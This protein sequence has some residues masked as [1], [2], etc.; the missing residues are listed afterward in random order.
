MP[1][2]VEAYLKR[3]GPS[4]STEV[5]AHLV[6]TLKVSAEAARQRV[7]RSTAAH[8]LS[9]LTF[10]RRARFLYLQPQFGSPLYW[11]AL[12]TALITTNSA[13]GFAIAALRQ[14]GGVVTMAR[15]P[16][17]CG[18]PVRQSK[19]LAPETILAR[20]EGAGLVKRQTLNGLGECVTLVQAEGYYD[21]VGPRLQADAVAESILLL[22]VRDWLRK[23][24]LASYNVIALRG[25]TPPP[26]VGTFLWDLSGPSYIY[27]LTRR[28]GVGRRNGFV[29]CDVHLGSPMTPSGVEPFVRKCATLRSLTKVGGCLQILVAEQ[30]DQRAFQRL[31]SV[32]VIAATPTSL[33]GQEVAD[34][35]RELASVLENAA[36]TAI[37]P[38]RFEQLF[39]VLSKIDGAANQLRGTLFEYMA[40]ELA[41]QTLGPDVRMNRMFKVPGRG[42]AE[43]DVVAVRLNHGITV[44]ECK[45]YSPRATIPDDKF[46]RWLQHSV[47]LCHAAIQTHP[48]WR[49][50]TPH[51]E[52]WSTA[53]LSDASMRLFQ[54]AQAAINPDRYTIGLRLNDRLRDDCRATNDASLLTAFEKHFVRLPA[55]PWF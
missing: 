52:F 31:R 42:E 44:I 30:F 20:L 1:D 23:L 37:D 34:S 32:G 10:P 11:D 50:Y 48:D 41:R 43:A 33:F 7:Y 15:F 5:S 28:S 55:E 6:K 27:P 49:N 9:G 19:H 8:A 36:R 22:A 4:L 12:T 40:A 13:Y 54:D 26:K 21:W 29:V 47:P 53:G 14:R 38:E 25:D 45:G 51:F 16:T 18:A 46:Q 17:V 35:L 24:N 39:Q 2:P 3:H